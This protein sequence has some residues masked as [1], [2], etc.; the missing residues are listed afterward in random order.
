MNPKEVPGKNERRWGEKERK[1][2]IVG[3]TEEKT[4]RV[5]KRNLVKI[6]WLPAYD[7]GSIGEV[8]NES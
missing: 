7:D 1:K 6:L 3:A 5:T 4:Q 2:R 8:T